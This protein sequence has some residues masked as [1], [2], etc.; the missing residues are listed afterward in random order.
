MA[1][2]PRYRPLGI[3]AT[4][5]PGVNFAATGQA[6]ARV[7]QTIANSLDRMSSFAFREAEIQAKIEGAEYGAGNA[8]TAQ[9]LLAAQTEEE[10]QELTPGGTGTI[11]DRA[12]REAALRVISTTLE[13][14]ARGEIAA[15]RINAEKNFTPVDE[16]QSEID[17]IINGY[18][19]A[20]FD[21]SPAGAPQLRLS[22]SSVGNSAA[23]SHNTKMIARGEEQADLTAT[24]GMENIVFSIAE[25]INTA[26]SKSSDE[27]ANIVTSERI[28]LAQIAD[29]IN[30]DQKFAKYMSDFNEGVN[31]AFIG[32]VSDWAMENPIDHI[33]QWID[34]EIEDP[35]I[36]NI[37]PLMTAE[38]KRDARKA[39]DTAESD[40]YAKEARRNEVA[41]R[42]AKKAIRDLSADFNDVLIGGDE[43]EALRLYEELNPLDPKLAKQ[44]YEAFF[45]SGGVD[46][47][48][49]VFDLQL[50][51]SRGELSEGM[52][53]EAIT[54]RKLS[55][56]KSGVFL[57]KLKS[58]NNA[59]HQ[60]AMKLVRGAFGIP[61]AGL[62]VMDAA[63]NRAEAMRTVADFQ[64]RLIK[65]EKQ[66]P[67]MDRIAFADQFI[68]EGRAIE[69]LKKERDDL[70]TKVNKAFE[71][72]GIE[73]RD[74]MPAVIARSQEVAADRP[75]HDH[76][77]FL[78]ALVRINEINTKLG[79]SQ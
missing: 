43:D 62:F 72:L 55:K 54:D 22:L 39:I 36:K 69:L 68:K 21:I 61:D 34:G 7:A 56:T 44:Y 16:L 14:A 19:G 4:S 64:S 48:D 76:Q 53:L 12:A 32:I 9:Q 49:T 47:P 13:T 27:V 71:D 63:G 41:E 25:R 75:D 57:E 66:D 37:L 23:I 35:R 78:E 3:S 74:N 1:R 46:D 51:A 18:T 40:F 65:A 50:A 17:G 52:I 73:D 77:G 45:V 31:N 28:K 60:D 8:P 79:G 30:D 2:L 29:I 24:V 59:D 26:S 5:L 6:Q 10:R 38:Q 33:Q 42:D 15:A 67:N 70:I 58:Q 20:L 11:Y